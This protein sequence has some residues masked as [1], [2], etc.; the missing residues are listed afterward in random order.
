[1]KTSVF[2][3]LY[4]KSNL[5]IHLRQLYYNKYIPLN[6]TLPKIEGCLMVEAY[7]NKKKK[8]LKLFNGNQFKEIKKRKI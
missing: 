7:N 5:K 1:M 4:F 6:N 2:L 8:F 3:T